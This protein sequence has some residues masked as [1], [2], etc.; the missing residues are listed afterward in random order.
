MR[1]QGNTRIVL[2]I[3][4]GQYE[5]KGGPGYGR[6]TDLGR[7]QAKLAGEHL[8]AR[9]R[10]DPLLK[11]SMLKL[12]SSAL[13]RAVETAD[14]IQAELEGELAWV[15]VRRKDLPDDLPLQFMGN[16]GEHHLEFSVTSLST[17]L[18]VHDGDNRLQPEVQIKSGSRLR[19]AKPAMSPEA[20]SE[21]VALSELD[22]ETLAVHQ[23]LQPTKRL[24]NRFEEWSCSG[25][26]RESPPGDVH[27]SDNAEKNGLGFCDA[28]FAAGPAHKRLSPGDTFSRTT[29]GVLQNSLRQP[30][31]K[32]LNEADVD[33]CSVLMPDDS[34]YKHYGILN[35]QILKD[36]ASVNA[37][38]R[39]HMHRNVDHNSLRRA[40]RTDVISLSLVPVSG[41]EVQCRRW[42]ASEFAQLQL[43]DSLVCP[44]ILDEEAK[45]R[46]D[47]DFLLQ[48]I[49]QRDT[50]GMSAADVLAEVA[51]LDK[52]IKARRPGKQVE[53]FVVHQ[54]IIRY[55]FLRSLQFDTTAWL[56][57][58]GSNCT[59][60]QLRI[61]ARGDVI[62]DFFGDHGSTLPVSHY[63]YNSS[64][65]V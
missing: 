47:G 20:W 35:A 50:A 52:E 34:L 24:D 30:N 23:V 15:D 40:D 31:D 6:L 14:I 62:C 1:C 46:T 32:N 44:F 64:P 22:I 53:I 36:N 60:T 10:A 21:V 8:V 54:N 41:G 55:L 48:T 26:D 9:M 16:W 56:N 42:T 45:V 29:E 4:H 59:F 5:T 33:T 39:A 7:E 12:T 43:S 3:R 51:R 13:D 37:A 18:R 65:D 63:T 58:G 11:K 49:G 19:I 2:F 57:F 28:C 17:T 27:W 38:F 61:T 25:C